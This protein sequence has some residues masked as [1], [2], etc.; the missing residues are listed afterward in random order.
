MCP[1]TGRAWLSYRRA[2]EIFQE[3]ARLLANPLSE[4]DGAAPAE[5]EQQ[6]EPDDRGMHTSNPGGC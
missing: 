1:E 4:D 6:Q 2:E 3:N 5:R